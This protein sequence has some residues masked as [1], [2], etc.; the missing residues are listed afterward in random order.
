MRRFTVPEALL[1]LGTVCLMVFTF[2]ALELQRSHHARIERML[3]A[4]V[5]ARARAAPEEPLS[6]VSMP[7]VEPA[8]LPGQVKARKLVHTRRTPHERGAVEL[9]VSAECEGSDDP[10]CGLQ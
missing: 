2:L 10:L 4:R 5:E 6:K 8:T 9:D 1:T 7:P 3:A